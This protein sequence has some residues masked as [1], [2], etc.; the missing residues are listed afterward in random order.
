MKK[1]AIIAACLLTSALAYGQG[2]ID[3]DTTIGM[4]DS[5]VT[6]QSL[7]GAAAP[8]SYVAQ[9]YGGLAADSLAPIGSPVNF[10]GD[11]E[12]EGAGYIIGGAVTI[13][14]QYG[15]VEY[16]VQMHAWN[17]AN[18]AESGMSDVLTIANLGGKFNETDP[19]ANPSTLAGLQG[20][21]IVP[22]PSTIAL[23][24]LGGASLLLFRRRK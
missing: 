18:M 12:A 24:L 8:S 11:T 22:E 2:Q 15:G 19:A 23:G 14:G 7:G 13:D 21:T 3:F 10:F 16:F 1:L 4:P 5:I 20:F 17:P 6:V 9:L